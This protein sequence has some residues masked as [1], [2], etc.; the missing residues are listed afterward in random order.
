M[1]GNKK[2][3]DKNGKKQPSLRQFF[4]RGDVRE[5]RREARQAKRNAK[6]IRQ[7]ATT[8]KEEHEVQDKRLKEWEARNP[9]VAARRRA[10]VYQGQSSGWSNKL[11]EGFVKEEAAARKRARKRREEVAAMRW[12]VSLGAGQQHVVDL[13]VQGKNVLMLGEGGTGKTEVIKQLVRFFKQKKRRVDLT[14]STGRAALL[15][16]GAT[17]HSWAAIGLGRDPLVKLVENVRK[18]RYARQRWRKA[19]LLVI[20]EISMISAQLLDTLDA[21][22]RNI[23]NC[24]KPFGGIQLLGSGDFLQLPPIKAEYCFN[25]KCFDEVFS[26]DARVVLKHNYR[27]NSDPVFQRILKRIRADTLQKEDDAALKARVGLDVPA[28]LPATHIFPR[29][30]QVDDLN[31]GKLAALP[32]NATAFDARF[33]AREAV[34]VAQQAFLQRSLVSSAP[35]EVQLLLKPGTRVMYTRNNQKLKK[36]N[37]SLGDVVGFDDLTGFPVVRFADGDEIC[38]T[39]ETWSTPC[40]KMSMTQLP[41]I[42]AWAVTAHKIQGA[43]V[44]AA[45]MDVGHAI[46]EDNQAYTI[47]SRV[48]TLRGCYLLAYDPSVIRPNA[49]AL[50]FYAEL[51]MLE[52]K[53]KKQKMSELQEMAE[54]VAAAATAGVAPTEDRSG[55]L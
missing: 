55:S 9:E 54:A 41:L 5:K 32:G 39:P 19:Q 21:I 44:D 47:L 33:A 34:S 8:L 49:E 31:R 45:I 16:G 42:I 38:V 24:D 37:G 22:A 30:R 23:R 43:T 48:K 11:P 7:L 1:S 3:P 27:Q 28:D 4:Y 50:G 13:I 29:R 26:L 15:I 14:A 51:Q 25:A 52:G 17:L 10:G 35:C 53:I 36:V 12:S 2:Q 20:D 46:F 6:N 40:E 18:D